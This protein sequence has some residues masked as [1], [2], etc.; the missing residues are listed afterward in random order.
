MEPEIAARIGCRGP[1]FEECTCAWNGT[2]EPFKIGM[3]VL[4]A[5]V[6]FALVI[7]KLIMG[8]SQNIDLNSRPL[9]THFCLP[10]SGRELKKTTQSGLVSVELRLIPGSHNMIGQA[11]IGLGF[12]RPRQNFHA[13]T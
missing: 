8:S 4:V 10:R 11:C 6:P 3:G 5:S 2:R 13:G 12:I 1:I 7:Y 9:K